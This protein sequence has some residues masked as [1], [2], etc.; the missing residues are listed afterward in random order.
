VKEIHF[1]D[2][3]YIHWLLSAKGVGDDE[4]RDVI[5]AYLGLDE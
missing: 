2:P 1:E 4:A 5:R 3:R